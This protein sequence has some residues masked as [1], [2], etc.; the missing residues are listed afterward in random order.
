M[1]LFVLI[2]ICILLVVSEVLCIFIDE[3]M[4]FSFF[5]VVLLSV[6]LLKFFVV[7]FVVGLLLIMF[8]NGLLFVLGML[9]SML[10]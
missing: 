10:K 1:L 7:R 8:V 3:F 5:W 6:R 4:I 9:S 2:E